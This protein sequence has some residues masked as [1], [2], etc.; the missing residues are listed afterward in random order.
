MAADQ[1]S[2]AMVSGG[3]AGGISRV[4]SDKVFIAQPSL[5]ETIAG[6][7]FSSD[8]GQIVTERAVLPRCE[9]QGRLKILRTGS[10]ASDPTIA[11]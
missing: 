10:V 3:N 11:P 4:S 1:G 8:R 7:T 9:G 6:M 2:A 5:R